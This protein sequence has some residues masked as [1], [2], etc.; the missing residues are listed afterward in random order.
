VFSA[1][2]SIAKIGE[3]GISWKNK[4]EKAES[5]AIVGNSRDFCS[6]SNRIIA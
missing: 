4:W 5:D 3:I 6:M 2:T 1:V